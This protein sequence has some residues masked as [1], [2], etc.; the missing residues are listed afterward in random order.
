L[1]LPDLKAH[2]GRKGPLVRRAPLVSVA[3]PA[4]L[5][6]KDRSVRK[7][8]RATPVHRG[9]QGLPGNAAKLARRDLPGQRVIWVQPLRSGLLP[10]QTTLAAPTT[11]S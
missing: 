9:Q 10:G 11:K 2:K 7:V 1:V 4:R 5:A 3:K 6:R 8:H